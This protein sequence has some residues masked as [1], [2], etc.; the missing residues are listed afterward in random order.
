MEEAAGMEE[1]AT[2]MGEMAG[3]DVA[4]MKDGAASEA[5]EMGEVWQQALAT[6][7]Q[8]T[9]HDE[10]SQALLGIATKAIATLQRIANMAGVKD[11][12]HPYC[13]LPLS[14]VRDIVGIQEREND[15]T[16]MEAY[17][18]VQQSREL[19]PL[20][21]APACLPACLPPT[22]LPVPPPLASSCLLACLLPHKP[23]PQ[24][25][26]PVWPACPHAERF[27]QLMG[28]EMVLKETEHTWW[29][30]GL[31]A[32]KAYTVAQIYDAAER[33]HGL[34]KQPNAPDLGQVRGKVHGLVS[35]LPRKRSRTPACLRCNKC[36]SCTQP[37]RKKACL[38]PLL[39][40]LV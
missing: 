15:I 38:T 16:F 34:R 5:A 10:A 7:T 14:F 13:R 6:A 25:P 18:R 30:N 40:P 24:A 20:D 28:M 4:G 36:L 9:V 31:E 27:K 22:S 35:L 8:C 17:N 1:E 26:R 29:L 32:G 11:N 19:D 39:A 3:L 37:H 33:D 21:G 12:L 2:W 23:F